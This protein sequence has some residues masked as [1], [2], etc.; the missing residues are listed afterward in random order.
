MLE[1]NDDDKKLVS[2]VERAIE[3][4]IASANAPVAVIKRIVTIAVR[5]RNKGRNAAIKRHPFQGICENS[6]R[7][8]DRAHAHLDEIRSELGYADGNVRWVCPKANNSGMYSC[9]GC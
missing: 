6:K 2:R 9:G 4:A 5:H 1:L 3:K 8:L 7:P